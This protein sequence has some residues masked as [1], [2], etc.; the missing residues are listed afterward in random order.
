MMSSLIEHKKCL[1]RAL[2]YCT[3]TRAD[4]WETNLYPLS[5]RSYSAVS[6]T[7]HETYVHTMESSVVPSAPSAPCVEKTSCSNDRFSG[8]PFVC[9]VGLWRSS[10]NKLLNHCSSL[11]YTVYTC[12]VYITMYTFA[13]ISITYEHGMQNVHACESM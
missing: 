7:R 8:F 12:A 11:R 2:G 9:F 4:D 13:Q 3:S 1:M 6:P 10:H 5:N